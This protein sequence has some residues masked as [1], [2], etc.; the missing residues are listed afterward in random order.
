MMTKETFLQLL[1]DT[2]KREDVFKSFLNKYRNT[3]NTVISI[4]YSDKKYKGIN[5][6]EIFYHDFLKYVV[7]QL[8]K[9]DRIMSM[10]SWVLALAKKRAK[11]I[12]QKITKSYVKYLLQ[13]GGRENWDNFN[14]MLRNEFSPVIVKIVFKYFD[15]PRY[16][17]F[18]NEVKS[19]LLMQLYIS[20]VNN[21]AP[22]E[23]PIESID[24]YVYRMLRNLA[25]KKKVREAISIDLGLGSDDVDFS[26]YDKSEEEEL[27]WLDDEVGVGNAKD[28]YGQD[29]DNETIVVP[30]LHDQISY[31]EKMQAEKEVESYINLLPNKDQAEL[32]RKVR[33]YGYDREVLADEEGCTRAYLD[34]RVARAMTALYKVAL[35]QI[36]K[37][38][39]HMYLKNKENLTDEYYK[40]ILDGFF[41]T[42]RSLEE[43]AD[44]F[45]K[46]NKDFTE[47]LVAA[48]KEV[49]SIDAKIK[50][51]YI[52]EK[53]IEQYEEEE[54][55]D[56]A[57]R[58][59][60]KF[61]V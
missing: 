13:T 39:K 1:K 35:P 14:V 44:A 16:K 6:G 2:S 22:I 24:A 56:Q 54:H 59:E 57:F 41:L 3:F 17:G 26:K 27:D 5:I 30:L 47:T 50:K 33:L 46:N 61:N 42:D 53:D 55:R 48:F 7:D 19:S 49:K 51:I 12:S 9:T 45:H 60:I 58:S 11:D 18:Y 8:E 36:K 52:N 20:R 21:P 31:E 28:D 37:R 25:I 23:K 40:S 29:D 43:L 38:C 15:H 34:T 4:Q 10:D 32:I